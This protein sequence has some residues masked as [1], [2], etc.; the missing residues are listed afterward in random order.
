MKKNNIRITAI[1]QII[2]I[3]FLLLTTSTLGQDYLCKTVRVKHEIWE[4]QT[5]A[6]SIIFVRSELWSE[7]NDNIVNN[8]IEIPD[9]IFIRVNIM[10]PV[11]MITDQSTFQ[12][13][14]FLL[15][16]TLSLKY[17]IYDDCIDV[18]NPKLSKE[19]LVD[20]RKFSF[21][22]IK[23]G[24]NKDDIFN[25]YLTPSSLSEIQKENDIGLLHTDRYDNYL[26]QIVVKSYLGFSVDNF[27]CE[28]EYI[29]P[30][31][32]PFITNYIINEW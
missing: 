23:D 32:A 18:I 5:Q 20:L 7:Y 10:L 22:E 19:L 14:S 12:D 11:D 27:M 26:C 30:I 3:T 29:F 24:M 16:T 9:T 4:K 2:Q 15:K 1:R 13:T 31:C 21:K 6:D 28:S 25:I 17:S 8:R